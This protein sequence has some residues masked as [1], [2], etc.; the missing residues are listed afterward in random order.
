MNRGQLEGVINAPGTSVL[1]LSIASALASI[2]KTGE[3][4]RLGFLL[5]RAVGRPPTM[6]PTDAEEAADLDRFASMPLS[7]LVQL[8]KDEIPKYEASLRGSSSSEEPRM[9][10]PDGL[11]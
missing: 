2:A 7:E 3:I 10:E 9:M 11:A 6:D 1:D 8:A 5:D 4:S